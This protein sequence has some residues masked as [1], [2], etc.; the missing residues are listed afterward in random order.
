MHLFISGEVF[1]DVAEEFSR[2]AESLENRIN[3]FLASSPVSF[4]E[5][6]WVLVAIILPEGFSGD[7]PEIYK[8]HKRGSVVEFRLAISHPDFLASDLPGKTRLL[9]STLERCI[10]LMPALGVCAQDCQALNSI[11]CQAVRDLSGRKL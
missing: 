7:F 1:K 8:H 9:L 6:K 4:Y 3:S 2:I 5:K 10:A 11:L